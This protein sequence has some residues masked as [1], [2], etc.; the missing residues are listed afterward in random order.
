MT[1]KLMAFYLG[2]ILCF[3]ILILFVCCLV[4]SN[5]FLN[6]SAGEIQEDF[7]IL[8]G[9]YLG[10]KPP[11]ETPELFAPGI[12]STCVQHSSACF[13]LD[14]K[15]MV[16][17][18]MFPRPS[19]ILYM[20]EEKGRWTSPQVVAEGLTPFLTAD[21]QRIFFSTW[22][23]WVMD[24][25]HQ[26]WSKPRK[27]SS[28]V[29]FQKR[30]DGPSVSADGTLYF[31]SMWGDQDGIYRAKWDN[32]YFIE[33]EKLEYGISSDHNDGYPYI[34]HDESFLLFGSFR[35]GS[36]GM[37]DL[38]VSFQRADGTWT[39][40]KNLGRKI[41][42][43]AKDV[44]PFVSADGKYLFFMS[45]RISRLNSYRIPDGPGNVYWVK[46]D[47]LERIRKKELRR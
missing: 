24:K 38:Y 27:L 25:I 16:F 47:F 30:Q 44:H 9:P 42:S 35:P 23:L 7:P 1:K 14:G 8:K 18:R 34:A 37:S 39:Q 36:I 43:E 12:V 45:S 31:C 32:G 5:S 41:N 17:S 20:Q 4:F 40:P 21:G 33:R 46:A 11:G 19:V 28:V 26:G 6:A 22:S 3:S 10:Q 2:I 15:E 13:S 29:N